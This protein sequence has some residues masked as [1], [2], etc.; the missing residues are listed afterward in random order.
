LIKSPSE[1]SEVNVVEEPV[2][3]LLPKTVFTVPEIAVNPLVKD[4]KS[5]I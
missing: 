2:T 5:L 1:K 4:P 3:I